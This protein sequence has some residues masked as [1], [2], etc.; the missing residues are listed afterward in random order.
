MKGKNRAVFLDR[1]G[2]I[3]EVLFRGGEKPIAPWRLEEF[4]LIPG[5]KKPLEELSNMGYS[6]FVV[7]NQPDIA[8]GYVDLSVV[9]KMNEII[10]ETLPIQDIMICPHDDSQNC[11]CRK[12]KPGM[13]LD[14]AK[15]WKI[16]LKKSFLIGDNWRDIGAGKAVGCKTVIIDKPHNKAIKADYRIKNLESAVKIISQKV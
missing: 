4:K 8:K 12:P 16:D 5:I 11:N 10:L 14:L 7:S 1:D 6:L 13:L 9:E 2:V 3:N 15:K